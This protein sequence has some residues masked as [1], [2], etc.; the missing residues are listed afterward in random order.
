MVVENTENSEKNSILK[1]FIPQLKSLV[2]SET[3]FGEPYKVGEVTLIPVNS[4]KVGFGFGNGEILKNRDTGGGGGGVLLTP[5]AFI[6][7]KGDMVT[8]ESLSSG[9]IESVIEKVP[10]LVE[11]LTEIIKRN[12]PSKKSSS[13]KSEKE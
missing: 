10:G 9:T 6:V 11:K 4:V 12:F 13:E 2:Q 8:I 7:I 1:E 3:V 5:V